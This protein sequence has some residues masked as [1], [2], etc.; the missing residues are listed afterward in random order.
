[1]AALKPPLT[2]EVPRRGWKG[3]KPQQNLLPLYIFAVI[4]SPNPSV[5]LRQPAPLSGEPFAGDHKGRPYIATANLPGC[6]RGGP[7]WPPG[8]ATSSGPPGHLPLKGEGFCRTPFKPPLTGEVP[9]KGAEGFKTA[10][11]F[12]PAL[13]IRGGD[14][15]KP[16]SR[17]R[18]QLPFQGSLLRATARVAP[19]LPPPI[20]RD[21]VGAAL[22]GRPGKPPHPALRATFPSKGKAFTAR[23]SC[24]PP[25]G[26]RNSEE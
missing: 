11:E 1:M 24:L 25:G 19:T 18:R 26:G 2:G 7:A 17:L 14:F 20:C 4:T 10:A 8:K 9:P 23:L 13:H 21:A 12:T 6:R 5:C 3:L 16:L 22:R 15:N